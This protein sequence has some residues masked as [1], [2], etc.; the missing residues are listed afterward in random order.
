M[1]VQVEPLIGDIQTLEVQIEN[2]WL[3]LVEWLGPIK[4]NAF[5]KD[6]VNMYVQISVAN[7]IQGVRYTTGG[8]TETLSMTVIDD[9]SRIGVTKFANQ[10]IQKF[11]SGVN[12][13]IPYSAGLVVNVS[14][15]NRNVQVAGASTFL[16]A[17]HWTYNSGKDMSIR[18]ANS[19]ADVGTYVINMGVMNEI[20]NS[21]NQRNS[22][23]A[24]GYL[25]NQKN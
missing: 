23:A 20:A 7:V 21:K 15:N 11:N 24:Q 9:D 3:T 16:T 10:T 12:Y 13:Q 8:A 5:Y 4:V 25:L 18:G 17:T 22:E 14:P 2:Q 19:I 6:G 1:K